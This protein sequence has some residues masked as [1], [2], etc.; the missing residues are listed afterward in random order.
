MVNLANRQAQCHLL[1]C[2]SF[3]R[4]LLIVL[5][6][7]EITQSISVSNDSVTPLFAR[8]I[9]CYAFRLMIIWS[10]I[11]SSIWSWNHL[12]IV[13]FKYSS[14][15]NTCFSAWKGL[16]TTWTEAET[17]GDLI[18]PFPYCHAFSTCIV[19]KYEILLVYDAA[20]CWA[21][22]CVRVRN[23]HRY[24][25]SC[26]ELV[27]RTRT[28]K[29]LAIKNT[30]K[31]Y[32]AFLKIKVDGSKVKLSIDAK[33]YNFCCNFIPLKLSTVLINWS[34]AQLIDQTLKIIAQGFNF[35]AVQTL[36][37]CATLESGLKRCK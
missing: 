1:V 27:A 8:K 10:S 20:L 15:Q 30:L 16:D 19:A 34:L 3:V 32:M 9:L 21:S 22:M 36:V 25:A 26:N 17:P 11:W 2:M 14:V 29:K 31:H 24:F 35:W 5:Q 6:V 28:Q 12:V 13:L 23:F 4:C 37:F 18:V 7:I 33:P